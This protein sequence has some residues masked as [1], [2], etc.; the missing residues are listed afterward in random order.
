M[1][2]MRLLQKENILEKKTERTENE[3][4]QFNP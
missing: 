2:L 1:D 3:K 4:K